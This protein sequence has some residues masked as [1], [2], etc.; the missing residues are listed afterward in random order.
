MIVSANTKIYNEVFQQYYNH[1]L[2]FSRND[3]DNVHNTYIKTLNRITE[4]GF[5]AHTITELKNKLK[6]YCKT[7]IYN[8]FK[9]EKK[10]KKDSIEI[11]WN[12]ELQLLLTE[13]QLENEKLYHE[14]LEYITIK[15]FE[16]LKRNHS[17]EDNYVFRVYYLY[18]KNN[19]KIT[20]TRLSEITG[21]S[22]SKVCGIIQRMKADLKENLIPYIN[23]TNSRRSTDSNN[24]R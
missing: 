23:A 18:D 13:K 2:K 21:F 6:I 20:Y 4:K 22:I 16:Y 5:T 3:E 15:L 1:F 19:K 12:A 7:V 24:K 17:Q 8:G 10:L 9:T 14:E 11:D